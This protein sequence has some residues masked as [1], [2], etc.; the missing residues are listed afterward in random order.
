[1]PSQ[2]LVVVHAHP[3][4][5][6]IFTAATMVRAARYGTRV[7]LVAATGGEQGR[8]LIPLQ[9]G[10]TMLQ[11]RRR[12]LERASELLGVDRLVLLGYADTGFDRGGAFATGSLGATSTGEVARR[13]VQLIEE[14]NAVA[15]LHYDRGG[16]YGHVDH[17]RVHQAG[18]LAARR[19]GV[20]SYEATVDPERIHAQPKHLLHAASYASV[21]LGV[22]ARDITLTMRANRTELVAK[23]AAMSAHASQIR[24]ADLPRGAAFA[25]GYGREWYVRR[26]PVGLLDALA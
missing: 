4:D 16:I 24:A 6:A 26:G 14:E 3:D 10:E 13:L 2:T 5:E 15:L 22:P 21:P 18:R 11:R 17:V 7:V 9:R 1:M 19:L 12:E 23:R 8:S 20:T 25:A